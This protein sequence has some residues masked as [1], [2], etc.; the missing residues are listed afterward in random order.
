MISA[1]HRVSLV[2]HW[3][4]AARRLNSRSGQ[5]VPH[6]RG[7]PLA[8]PWGRNA[9]RVERIGD[10]PECCGASPADL[11]DYRD[12]IGRV[13]IRSGLQSL[14]GVLACGSQFGAAEL[15]AAPARASL[16][17]RALWEAL[18]IT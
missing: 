15:H 18:T 8:T 11:I 10:I 3:R 12:D 6:T 7:I 4:V 1:I 16:T 2:R 13:S 14:Y 5:D 17:W 9:P